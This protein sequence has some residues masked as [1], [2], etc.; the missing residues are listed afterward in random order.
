MWERL[1]TTDRVRTERE[2]QERN[3]GVFTARLYHVAW[4]RTDFT[5][6]A[7]IAKIPKN[8]IGPHCDSCLQ[9]LVAHLRL[10]SSVGLKTFNECCV[11]VECWE[12]IA[13]RCFRASA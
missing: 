4:N 7:G 5:I 10:G 11:I 13:S 1:R 2:R 9:N 3:F 6:Y 12:S 8:A